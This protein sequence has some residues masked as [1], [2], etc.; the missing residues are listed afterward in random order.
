[1]CTC[2]PHFAFGVF[3]ISF[4]HW[5]KSW[6][7]RSAIPGL[8]WTS[9]THRWMLQSTVQQLTQH[10]F[11]QLALSPDLFCGTAFLYIYKV[12]QR[13]A[14]FKNQLKTHR[15]KS[16]FNINIL[17]AYPSFSI[18][19]SCLHV[20]V[21][22]FYLFTIFLVLFC[23]NVLILVA[24]ALQMSRWWC[25]RWRASMEHWFLVKLTAQW[26]WQFK[27]REY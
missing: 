7:N 2:P 25:W 23:T 22:Y 20:Y 3:I 26:T 24:G 14:F 15:F 8:V 13:L 6:M 17:Q 27:K 11:K 4:V 21:F 10:A 12:S 1:M 19:F 5:M 18:I 9:V 16:A